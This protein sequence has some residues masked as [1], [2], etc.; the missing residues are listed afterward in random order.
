M[1]EEQNK[2]LPPLLQMYPP[3]FCL[4][5]SHSTCSVQTVPGAVSFV[6]NLELPVPWERILSH[7]E[8]IFLKWHLC[9]GLELDT[10][11]Y[12][13]THIDGNEWWLCHCHCSNKRSLQC[14]SAAV[15]VRQLM[16]E[17][18]DG[19]FFNCLWVF[20]R[21]FVNAC[22][23]EKFIYVGSLYFR[24]FHLVY[25]KCGND[26]DAHAVRYI[27]VGGIDAV[28][29][30]GE[31]SNYFVLL[32]KSCKNRTERQAYVCCKKTRLWMLKAKSV[33]KPPKFSSPHERARLRQF[34]AHYKFNTP[35]LKLS[36]FL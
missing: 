10:L 9:G 25:I 20:Y 19:A 31:F 14:L 24:E 13:R 5:P 35:V 12:H 32:C 28:Y 3:R 1:E 23:P 17:I 6:P 27:Q 21:E 30:N 26:E 4:R 7:E 16:K 18:L 2:D 11:R 34:V 8:Y 22:M 36:G 15:V 29:C 33:C